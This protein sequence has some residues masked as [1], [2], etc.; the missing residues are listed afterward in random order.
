VAKPR[1]KGP[2]GLGGWLFIPASALILVPPKILVA[3]SIF[4]H[5]LLKVNPGLSG[6]VRFWLLLAID[7][8]IIGFMVLA[9]TYFFRRKKEAP[10]IFMS[11]LFM[12][13]IGSLLQELLMVDLGLR[14]K[15]LETFF[16]F[17]G[18]LVAGSLWTVYFLKSKRV[19]NTF[20][21]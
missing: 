8:V 3:D 13:A 21:K 17:I 18:T 10:K 12:S 2:E 9:A 15:D 19:K 14:S 6:D 20:V 1:I 16:P 5:R 7:A 4:C 11:Y